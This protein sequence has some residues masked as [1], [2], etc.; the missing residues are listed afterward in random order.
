MT[1]DANQAYVRSGV[2]RRG[3]S[4]CTS[5]KRAAEAGFPG[6][7]LL[8]QGPEVARGAVRAL[9]TARRRGAVRALQT[10]RRRGA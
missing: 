1:G 10:A 5:D 8:T 6:P 4:P 9:Q 3:L 2:L 7:S